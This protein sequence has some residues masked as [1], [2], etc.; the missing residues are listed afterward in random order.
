MLHADHV[1][2]VT[3]GK[4]RDKGRSDPT[5]VEDLARSSGE[6][7]PPEVL[8]APSREAPWPLHGEDG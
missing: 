8:D 2:P 7:S 6:E 3:A 4:K 5:S 1:K